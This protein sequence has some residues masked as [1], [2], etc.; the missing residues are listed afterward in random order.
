MDKSKPFGLIISKRAQSFKP[1][2]STVF[3]DESD[4]ETI[5][6]KKKPSIPQ[7]KPKKRDLPEVSADP[8]IYE[9]DSI[10]D[11]MK[12]QEVAKVAPKDANKPSRYIESLL[13]AADKRKKDQERRVE[14]KVHHE[15]EL[16]GDKFKDK[17]A[18]VTSG[19]KKKMQEMEEEEERERRENMLNE[20]MDVTKQKDLSG[21]YRH[22]LKQSVGEEKIPVF[23]ER[24]AVKTEDVAIKQEKLSDEEGSKKKPSCDKDD[25]KKDFGP[26]DENSGEEGPSRKEF[27]CKDRRKG[28]EMSKI[29]K[30]ELISDEGSSSK[31]DLQRRREMDSGD[32]SKFRKSKKVSKDVHRRRQDIDSEDD[33]ISGGEGSSEKSSLRKPGVDS[34]LKSSRDDNIDR[35]T[36]IDSSSDEEPMDISK[37][38]KSSKNVHTEKGRNKSVVSDNIDQDSDISSS[39][40]DVTIVQQPRED[41]TQK[42]SKKESHKN[43]KPVMPTDN[44]DKD[45]DI[46]S[47][48]D[49]S[50]HSGLKTDSKF[51]RKRKRPTD[52]NKPSRNIRKR[53]EDGN[54]S[55]QY[56][57]SSND[58]D[59]KDEES[60]D[61][62]DG[63][64]DD[65]QSIPKPVE[66]ADTE[67]P[68]PKID[69]YAKRTVGDDFA[70][71]QARYFQRMAA[72]SA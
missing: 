61:K 53:V 63:D 46:V 19:Y 58:D 3:G 60:K 39:D 72:R 34:A 8:S 29:P 67:P 47:D 20:M 28:V 13:K 2:V 24:Y 68:K 31:K 59:Q 56:D 71:A 42:S 16:E 5:P 50:D 27:H 48:A 52:T 66:K 12:A 57:D 64:S 14:K 11:D 4:E 7:A 69:I 33:N 49:A 44:V 38:L 51:Q 25:K 70:E 55:A 36:D 15:R 30:E 22:F 54:S 40:E 1:T 37:D 9:Y 43:E 6:K 21:F 26:D 62:E 17:E 18:F 10:Y 32:V 65:E 35:D 41:L 23:G 45:S